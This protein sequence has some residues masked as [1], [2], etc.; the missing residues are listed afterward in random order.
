MPG[1]QNFSTFT[2]GSTYCI[3]CLTGYYLINGF[4]IN[5]A[6]CVTAD[7]IGTCLTCVTGY[8]LISKICYKNDIDNCLVQQ[9]NVCLQ[10]AN[11]YISISVYDRNYCLLRQIA[12]S[13]CSN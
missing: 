3:K 7:N 1:C 10:C 4:C 12:Y 5:D 9:A 11:G 6:N 2:N 8:Q 13:G